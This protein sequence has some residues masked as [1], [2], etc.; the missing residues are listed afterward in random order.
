MDHEETIDQTKSAMSTN[1]LEK[2]AFFAGKFLEVSEKIP[3]EM[4]C[5]NEYE[6]S[7]KFKV[8]SIDFLLK[9]RIVK[10]LSDA[11]KTGIRPIQTSLIY[12]EI[13]SRQFFY[14][15]VITNPYKVVWLLTP[16]QNHQDLIDESFY[17]CIKKV[18]D[19][20]LT[21]PVTEKSAP[22]ILKALEFFTNRSIGPVVQKI[23]QK[24]MSVN[25]DGSSVA[26]DALT[27]DDLQKKLD[28]LRAKALSAPIVVD[29]NEPN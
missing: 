5:L 26:R 13:C 15:N 28:E 7:Q 6:L 29:I 23:E 25:F 11:E 3:A 16:V 21:M 17:F 14:F 27:P 9:N 4:W 24:S 20:I 18:R 2:A 19:E 10:L 1:S 22:I 8:S 12:E